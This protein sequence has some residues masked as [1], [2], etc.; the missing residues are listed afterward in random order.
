MSLIINYC[1]P[2]FVKQQLSKLNPEALSISSAAPVNQAKQHHD[3]DF[4][5]SKY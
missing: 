2:P 1:K 3:A 4:W 5:V